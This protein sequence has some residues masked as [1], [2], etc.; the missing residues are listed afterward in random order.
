MVLSGKTFGGHI[1]LLCHPHVKS[2]NVSYEYTYV[3]HEYMHLM[4]AY[5]KT[6]AGARSPVQCTYTTHIQY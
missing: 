5:A 3:A 1:N 4:H 2:L 6:I